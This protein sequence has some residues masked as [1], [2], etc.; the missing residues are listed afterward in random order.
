M[1]PYYEDDAVTLYCGD[2]RQIDVGEVDHVITDPPYSDDT[3]DGARTANVQ[4]KLLTFDSA[5][6]GLIHSVLSRA[7][8]RRWVVA[9]IDWQ[10]ML[11]MK[12]H[13]PDGMRFVRHGVWV[14]PNGAPQFTGDRPGQG[15][16]A[17][18]ILHSTRDDQ[19]MSWN[20]GGR[21]A[22][23]RCARVQSQH[24]TCKPIEL[25]MSFIEQFT[26]EGD[27]I[28]DPFAGEGTTLVAAKRL[29]RRAIGVEIDSKW[30]DAAVRRLEQGVLAL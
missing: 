24:P 12:V 2:C 25:L 19:K 5:E 9:T 1:T 20:G 22:V 15:W 28:F 7:R 14:K 11:P 3:H 13:P 23:W 30:C 27:V 21:H 18:M 16:E 29:G 17:V 26:S 10:H 6:V 8:V 4:T